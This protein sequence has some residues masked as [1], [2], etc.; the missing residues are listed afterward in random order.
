MQEAEAQPSCIVAPLCQ[1]DARRLAF[2][3]TF[4][5]VLVRTRW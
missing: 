5:S 3:C 1:M 4:G 2:G